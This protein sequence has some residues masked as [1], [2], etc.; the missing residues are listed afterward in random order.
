M[1]KNKSVLAIIPARKGSKRLVGKNMLDLKE[2]PL[3]AWTIEEALKSK[4]IDNIIISTDD[5]NII[6]LS[7]Q[8]KGINVP[9]VRPKE[10]SSDKATSLDVVLHALNYYSSI[11]KNF[12]YV[13]LLQP[14]SPLRKSK[15]IDYSIEELSEEVKSVVSVCETEHSPLWSNILPDN[16]SMKNF[17]SKE[18]LN[19]RS[20]DLPKYYRLN[21]AIYISE[22]KYLVKEKG[23]FGD[24]TKAYTMPIERSIDIDDEIDFKFVEF[25][26][27]NKKYE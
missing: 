9:F 23:F 27:K 24:Q 10:L 2:K 17:L 4:Y 5:E 7:K 1:I 14:T 13:M 26:I 21:G 3:I 12:D 19:L 16:K 25:L 15:D 20:Q 6:N 18:F 8:Y 11:D 22:V